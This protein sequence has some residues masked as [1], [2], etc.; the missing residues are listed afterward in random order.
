MRDHSISDIEAENYLLYYIET[1]KELILKYASEKN[2]VIPKTL[3]NLDVLEEKLRSQTKELSELE[4]QFLTQHIF[5][6]RLL[7]GIDFGVLFI[8]LT[9]IFYYDELYFHTLC[10]GLFMSIFFGGIT[11]F[12]LFFANVIDSYNEEWKSELE[13][14]LK[15]QLF[16]QNEEILKQYQKTLSYNSIH[17]KKYQELK[18]VL[19]KAKKEQGQKLMRVRMHS[20]ETHS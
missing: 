12:G 8:G 5:W 20:S 16:Y 18:K 3:H 14:L 17:K 1:E 19:K 4:K 9:H 11:F 7:K 2:T 13:D 10:R 15:Y 6:L